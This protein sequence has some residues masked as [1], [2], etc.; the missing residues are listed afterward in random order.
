MKPITD[1]AASLG[2]H[3]DDIEP[4]GRYKAKLALKAFRDRPRRGKLVLVSAITPTPAGEGKTT[5]TIGLV[6]GLAKIGVRQ[7]VRVAARELAVHDIRVN[8][9]APGPTV[10]PM[11][12]GAGEM[13]GY[14]DHLAKVTPLGRLGAVGDIVDAVL[15]L[16]ALKWVTGQTLAADGGVTVCSSTDIPGLDAEAL[17]HW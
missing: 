16:L 17:S 3:P 8:A 1:V 10:T 6:Q 12:E 4:Y 13:T 2:I 9:I 15:A 14:F 5:T 11:M 7:L